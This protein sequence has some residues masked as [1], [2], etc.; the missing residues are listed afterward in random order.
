MGRRATY[1][2]VEL[3]PLR[4]KGVEIVALRAHAGPAPKTVRLVSDLKSEEARTHSSCHVSCLFRRRFRSAAR[5]VEPVDEP[6]IERINE[7][8]KCI[9]CSRRDDEGLGL[10]CIA[11]VTP[12]RA[13]AGIAAETQHG[14]RA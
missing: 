12:R 3:P 1:R 11:G 2:R 7:S 9:D 4:Y 5:K 13:F 8:C 14:A 10:R 6:P